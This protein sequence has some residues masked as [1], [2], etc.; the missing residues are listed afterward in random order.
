MSIE[1]TNDRTFLGNVRIRTKILAGSGIVL[2]MLA[3]VGGLSFF[4]F[5]HVA[6]NFEEYSEAAKLGV[7]S[8]EIAGDFTEINSHAKDF[9]LSGD[10][11]ILTKE[12][13][14]AAE[15]AAKID[16][17]IGLAHTDSEREKL[18]RVREVIGQYGDVFKKV[19]ALSAEERKLVDEVIMPD[20]AKLMADLE[21]VS[22]RA[23][24]S[25]NSEAL[26]LAMSAEIALAR[27]HGALSTILGLDKEEAKATFEASLQEMQQVLAGIDRATQG[28]ELRGIYEEM[29][30]VAKEYREAAETAIKDHMELQ[31]IIEVE[32]VD[33]EADA[34]AT[35]DDVTNEITAEEERLRSDLSDTIVTT[36]IVIVVI[37][38]SGFAL[39][40]VV[41]LLV[42][43]GIAR[44]VVM[45]ADVM[46]KLGDGDREIG[47]PATANRDEIGEMAR[48]VQ[49]F[50][51]GLIEA[52][53][54]RTIQEAEQ[55]RQV[56]RGKK[57]EAAVA[58]F[59]KVIGEVVGVVSA[60]ATEL[61][62]TAQ[63]LSATAEETAQQSNAV[64]A[65][66]EQMTQ[67]VQ[68]VASATEELSASIREINHQVSES[69]RIVG[70]AV[71]QAEDTNAK[72]NGLAAAAQKIGEV[73]TLINEIASQTNLLALNATIEAARAGEAGKG[74]AV[75]AS[76]VKNLATQTA[77]ATDE[78][79]AQ[80][81]AIQDST[82]GSAKAIVSITQ[83]INRVNE[84]STGIAS[85]V[86]EQG[87]ATAEISRNVQ[88]AAAGTAEVTS[89][90]IGV[91]Q[92]SQQTSA[93]S[94]QVL[95]AASELSENGVRLKREVESFLQTVRSL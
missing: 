67:N 50:K 14:L 90:I 34:R 48:S 6:R 64:A 68:T 92:A 42:A 84:I 12:E 21:E 95:S 16:D 91:T 43:G 47:V 54:L 33:M 31:R 79:A 51:E 73:V 49:V 38:L 57:M 72:V 69:T 86:E 27:G 66:S 62:A 55:R 58:E 61:Q 40:I 53:R 9:L 7:V 44:P 59:D 23:A 52:E 8:K 20:S 5:T 10:T 35:L 83:T 13:A 65:A 4:S 29:V 63:S 74:F 77:R 60:A 17:A 22:R 70:A 94:S 15:V 26:V 41:S 39:G 85:A 78:I 25:G 80:V 75:V 76:E 3:I 30:V 56:E 36:E 87:A 28:S 88:Q 71:E 46:K 82:E 18:Q 2:G 24:A 19:G 37:A 45:M 1:A 89:N 81:K 11:S 93:G 32:M